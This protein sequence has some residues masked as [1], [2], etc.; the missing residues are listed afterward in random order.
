[1]GGYMRNT[2]LG[3]TSLLA[4]ACSYAV[5]N[6]ALAQDKSETRIERI[7][8]T[9][10]RRAEDPQTAPIAVTVFDEAGLRRNNIDEIDDLEFATPSLTVATAG[11]ANMMN[12]RGVGKFDA[13]GT[14]T[15]AIATYRD[16][17]GTVSGFFN[18]EPYY[19]IE[20]VEVLRGPQ[21]TFFGENA[22]GGAILV[23]TRDPVI[24]GP[25]EGYLQAGIG[26]YDTHE[27][28]GA[29]NIP[30]DDWIAARIS[31]RHVDRDSFFDVFTN[32]AGTVP[33]P[34]HPGD[35]NHNSL[36][37]SV[38]VQP[39]DPLEVLFKVDLHNL[40]HGGNVFGTVP[41]H[42]SQPPPL[43]TSDLYR[44]A[45][46]FE[47]VLAK[48]KMARGIME[49]NYDL[50][51]A[52]NFRWISGIQ[53][54]NTH[55]RNDDDGSASVDNR[56]HIR[57]IF[58]VYTSE[59]TYLSPDEERFRWLIGAFFRREVLWFP[60][61]DG[62]YVYAGPGTPGT[63]I[64]NI[65]WRTPRQTEALYG[66][67]AYD[68]TD[69]LEIVAG[70]RAQHYKMEQVATTLFLGSIGFPFGTSGTRDST[71]EEEP[72]TYKVALNWE[73][74]DE[75]Y[76]YAFI[77]TG[78]TTGG[79]SVLLGTPPG[80]NLGFDN[81]KTTDYEA[82]WKGT[83]MEGQLLT[84]FGGFYTNIEDYQATFSEVITP[85]LT[86]TTFQNIQDDTIVYG[87][88]LQAQA[89]IDDFGLDF[90][91]AWIHSEL[92]ETVVRDVT[93][94]MSDLHTGGKQVPWTPNWTFN[95]GLEYDFHVF[96][97][98]TLTPRITYSWVDDQT[99]TATDRFRNGVYIDRIFAHELVNL[100][101]TLATEDWLV[102]AYMTNALEEQYIQAHSGDTIPDPDAYA[103]EPMRYGLRVTKNFGGT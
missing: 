69:E 90:N 45:N 33:H 100:Q 82:G 70:V 67:A 72:I 79:H 51:D 17:V 75:H 27:V 16:G 60:D 97:D 91:A 77:A 39:I 25:F 47:G 52:G 48:D 65:Q 61:N 6:G 40:D 103:N 42:P 23:N 74:T 36:R 7:V 101:L 5:T 22:A 37:A 86:R 18:H 26:N 96:E 59:A 89:K 80:P 3:S 95:I 73:A 63:E 30:I 99:V 19:D 94:P 11:Q 2:W 32:P 29:I 38:L 35:I 81:Q 98:A 93:P 102:Q 78:N 87:I 83:L 46:N 57:P 68:L 49:V 14:S 71:Y 15:S 13:G 58:R 85:T 53:Y 62:F 84:Q 76:F 28:Q 44:V 9:A 20:S 41:G 24:D 50:E 10:E 56:I 66:Q 21:G 1:M 92:G 64:L 4:L 31:Y 34:N 8:V 88:E 43:S 12:M 54:I 55:I